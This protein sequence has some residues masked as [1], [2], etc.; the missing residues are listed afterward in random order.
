M[1]TW[2]EHHLHSGELTFSGSIPNEYEPPAAID[3]HGTCKS[4]SVVGPIYVCCLLQAGSE[5]SRLLLQATDLSA[6]LQ[7]LKGYTTNIRSQL[8]PFQRSEAQAATT[9]NAM[10]GA[11]CAALPFSPHLDRDLELS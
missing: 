5:K 1:G 10:H 2:Q 9:S 3:T 8:L 4:C 7:E 11:W 6:T